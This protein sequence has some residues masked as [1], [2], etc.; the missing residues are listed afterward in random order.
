MTGFHWQMNR[1]GLALLVLVLGGA[2]A[3]AQSDR[4]FPKE[5]RTLTG[6]ISK[7][8]AKG[9]TIETGGREVE[10][11]ATEIKISGLSPVKLRRPDVQFP[12]ND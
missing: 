9:I 7:V 12:R 1:A 10:V 2:I 4:V 11:P 8:S 6:A 3:D 5:G